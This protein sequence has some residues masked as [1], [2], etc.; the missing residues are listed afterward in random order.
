MTLEFRSKRAQIL[1]PIDPFLIGWCVGKHEKKTA[2]QQSNLLFE[3]RG[4]S[5]I[6]RIWLFRIYP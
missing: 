5:L 2:V 4:T 6:H 3:Y 1:I